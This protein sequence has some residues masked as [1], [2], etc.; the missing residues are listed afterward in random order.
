MA[1][2]SNLL[3]AID[4]I[5]KCCQYCN[6]EIRGRSDKKF[7]D[8]Y[9]RNLFHNQVNAKSNKN[10]RIINSILK[11]NRNILASFLKDET[12]FEKISKE[13]LLECGFQFK[14]FTHTVTHKNGSLYYF[15]YDLGYHMLDNEWLLLVRERTK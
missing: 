11:K 8:D 4:S 14:Y 6:K 12:A 13:K 10:L 2:Y 7:C 1:A 9:C 5:I 15:C 3:M